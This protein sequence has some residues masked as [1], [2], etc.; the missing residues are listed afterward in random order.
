VR[1]GDLLRDPSPKAAGAALVDGIPNLYSLTAFN[2]RTVPFAAGINPI[3]KV[4]SSSGPRR[5][6]VLIRSSPH[7]AGSVIT[8][9]EDTFAPERGHVRYFGDNK[10]SKSGPA[11]DSEGNR[12]LLRLFGEHRSPLQEVRAHSAPLIFFEGTPHAGKHKGHVRFQGVGLIDRAEL[13]T[14]QGAEGQPFANYV[15]DCTVISLAAEA[16][17]FSWDW[18]NGRR[19]GLSD[20]AAL[21]LAPASWRDWVAQGEQALPR[22]RR[23]V[24]SL[25]TKSPKEQRPPE[26]SRE[27]KTLREVYEYYEGRKHRFE[28]LAELVAE[29]VVRR[30]GDAYRRGWITRGSGDRGID[31]VG[32]LDL[33]TGFGST[34]IVVLGQAKC[35][36]PST[37]TN[38]VH[39]ARTVA[40]LR[41]GWVGVYV[42][43]SF[44]STQVQEEVY[45]DRYPIV[46]VNGTRLAQEVNAVVV[47]QGYG[48]VVALLD[49]VDATYESRLAYRDPEEVLL[50]F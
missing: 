34:G 42:T 13:V 19:S 2:G 12:E 35:E 18:I 39:I 4:Q 48:G 9:W 49:A 50:A 29:R 44:F 30:S 15:Y 40:R 10:P 45:E 21:A 8:P 22:V 27:A 20:E 23:R 28:A 46:L 33:G 1:I 6:A 7:K 41:R 3:A 37:P 11:H 38:G 14:Q 16:E 43:T 26:G 24:A 5:P 17:H 31:F 32:R 47:E 25:L 36:S